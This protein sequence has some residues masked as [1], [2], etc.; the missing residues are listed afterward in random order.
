MTPP[1][2]LISVDPGVQGSGVC[3]WIGGVLV[4]AAYTAEAIEWMP[5]A[6]CVCELMKVYPG[7]RHAADL[8]DVSFAAGVVCAHYPNVIKVPA[9]EWKGQVPKDIHHRRLKKSAGPEELRVL[10]RTQVIPSLMHNVWDAYGIGKWY[11]G[12]FV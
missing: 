8:I 1:K 10:N 2:Y 3:L 9:A 5:T 4:H 12:R 6:V 7:A 11:L